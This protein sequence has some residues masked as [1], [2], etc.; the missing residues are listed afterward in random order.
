MICAISKTKTEK[1]PFCL[2]HVAQSQRQH[3]ISTSSYQHRDVCKLLWRR[4]REKI[5]RHPATNI[6]HCTSQSLLHRCLWDNKW[7]VIHYNDVIMSAMASQITSLTIVYWTVY[8]G[9]DQG[10]YQSLAS[11]SFVRG[12]HRWPVNSP[13]KRPVTRKMF[14]FD[15]V[16]NHSIKF[17]II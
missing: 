9:A 3:A 14:P 17:E 11:L 16:I 1:N 2:S 10:K 12:I 5:P 13:Y 6:F 7:N 15:D 4:P 8:S